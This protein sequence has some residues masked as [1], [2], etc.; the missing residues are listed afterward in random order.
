MLRCSM[1]PDQWKK[2]EEELTYFLSRSIVT[3]TIHRFLAL[4]CTQR[5]TP[6]TKPTTRS[7]PDICGVRLKY[8]GNLPKM[9]FSPL[10]HS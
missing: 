5:L 6:L 8:T 10:K 4:E 9:H 1:L 7:L 2:W 3:H